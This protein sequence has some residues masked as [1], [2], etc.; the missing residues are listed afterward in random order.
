M[1]ARKPFRFDPEKALEVFLY[2]ARHTPIPDIYHVL[3]VLYFADRQHLA[4]YGRLICG[5]EYY[6]LKDGPVPSGT[7]DLVRD[8]QNPTRQSP[9]ANKARAAFSLDGYQVKPLRDCDA[10]FLSR[11]DIKCLDD[12]INEIG[13]LPFGSVKALSHDAAYHSANLNGEI[14]VEDIASTLPD[15]K[16][17]IEQLHSY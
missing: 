17:L 7:Y 9:N 13:H 8:V 2:I 10:T 14:S 4:N 15:S 6:A 1:N 16:A 11:S 5:D 3:K 12:A